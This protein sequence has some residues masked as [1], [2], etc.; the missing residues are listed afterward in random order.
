MEKWADLAEIFGANLAKEQL[1]KKTTDFVVIFGATFTRN[2][3]V[4]H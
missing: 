2:R 4:L 1:V 3:S